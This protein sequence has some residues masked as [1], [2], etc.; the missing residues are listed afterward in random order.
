[1]MFLPTIFCSWPFL[2]AGTAVFILMAA[3]RRVGR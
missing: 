1:M 2:E 3:W